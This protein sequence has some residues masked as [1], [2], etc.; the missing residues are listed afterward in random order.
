MP[1]APSGRSSAAHSRVARP[2]SCSRPPSPSASTPSSGGI[3]RRGRPWRLTIPSLERGP[4]RASISATIDHWGTDAY[5]YSVWTGTQPETEHVSWGWL[6]RQTATPD[7]AVEWTGSRR[8]GCSSVMPSIAA[9]VLL[10][11]RE[12]DREALAYL[13]TLL[14]QPRCGS[15]PARM[16]EGPQQPAVLDAIREFV[17]ISAP[18]PNWTP[19][20]RRCCSPTSSAPPRRQPSWATDGG[21]GWSR[22]ITGESRCRSSI[23]RRRASTRRETDS[24]HRST[25][26]RGRSGATR[27][28]VASS[29]S[30]SRS[31]QACTPARAS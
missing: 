22:S 14:P 12:N 27:S 19:S 16:T 28:G 3:R 4:H 26:R 29:A 1:L 31:V 24:S 30:V 20:Y 15:S 13:A 10:L 18:R 25:A 8:H 21:R 23:A 2:T 11:A 5:G 7:V 9:P 17:G 6:S